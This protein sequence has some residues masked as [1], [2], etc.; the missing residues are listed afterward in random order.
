MKVRPR[1]GAEVLTVLFFDA[2]TQ[3][4]STSIWKA[5]KQGPFQ[6][7]LGGSVYWFAIICTIA[8][9]IRTLCGQEVHGPRFPNPDLT[10]LPVASLIGGSS[11]SAARI[12]RG[13]L[14]R[15]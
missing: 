3:S 15:G 8:R 14:R 5:D 10:R 13:R 6:T 7:W 2:P 9:A 4:R 11:W 1:K 12:R